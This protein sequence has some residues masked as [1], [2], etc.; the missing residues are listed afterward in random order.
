MLIDWFTVAA[1]AGNFLI[2][3]WL[4]KRYLY[5][6]ILNAIDAREAKIA[7][8]LKDAESKQVEATKQRDEFRQKNDALEQ[9]RNALLQIAQNDAKTER[10]KLHDQTR[11]DVEVLRAKLDAALQGERDA[12][13]REVVIG[14]QKEV[15]SIARKV[16]TDLGSANIEAQIT[17]ALVDRLLALDDHAKSEF[18]SA[19]KSSPEPVLVR[20]AFVLAGEQQVVIQLA[21][22]ETFAMEIPVKFETAPSLVCGI[23]LSMNGQKLAWS[24]DDYLTSLDKRMNEILA[25]A[26]KAEAEAESAPKIN[27]MPATSSKVAEIA[28]S[29]DA[30]PT[31]ST[32]A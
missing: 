31:V 17:K 23:E 5:Q 14:V 2:L 1:Q 7:A 11:K 16:L 28:E 18:S 22:K 19:L 13:K 3:V 8:G 10:Q 32:A 25:P 9:S 21:L 30:L 15:F 24:V 29:A 20:S 27:P 4:M 26:V 12:L 6:P